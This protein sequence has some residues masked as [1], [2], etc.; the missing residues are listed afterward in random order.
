MTFAETFLS[1]F[2]SDAV[3]FLLAVHSQG[4]GKY[5]AVKVKQEACAGVLPFK[6]R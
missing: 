1:L 2:I 4:V 6:G 5:T 3:S